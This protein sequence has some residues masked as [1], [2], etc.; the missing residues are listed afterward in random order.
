MSKKGRFP[1]PD[2]KRQESNSRPLES[3]ASH[4]AILPGKIAG[5]DIADRPDATPTFARSRAAVILEVRAVL[6]LVI[7]GAVAAEV[8]VFVIEALRP[9]LARVGLAII[10]VQL[11]GKWEA[12]GE[13]G[14]LKT[15]GSLSLPFTLPQAGSGYGI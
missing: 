13:R 14:R 9:V 10:Y 11:E 15:K 12:G 2:G 7:F 6:S 5:H 8:V 1:S 3:E 4:S